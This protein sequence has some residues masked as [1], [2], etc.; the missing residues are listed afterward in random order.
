M[1][2]IVLSVPPEVIRLLSGILSCLQRIEVEVRDTKARLAWS[3]PPQGAETPSVR[4]TSGTRPAPILRSV[5]EI[6]PA[7]RARSGPASTQTPAGP[8]AAQRMKKL[9]TRLGVSGVELARRLG[10]SQSAL[11]AVENDR[12]GISWRVHEAMQKLERNP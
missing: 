5:P 9:R 4:D 12:R 2:Q 7:Q 3:R 11:S 10:L 1:P 6:P 8:V